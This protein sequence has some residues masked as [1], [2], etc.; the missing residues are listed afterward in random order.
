MQKI[1][2]TIESSLLGSDKNMLTV[3][4]NALCGNGLIQ[5]VHYYSFSGIFYLLWLSLHMQL[6]H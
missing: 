3:A 6:T 1:P 4:S 2:W 5:M